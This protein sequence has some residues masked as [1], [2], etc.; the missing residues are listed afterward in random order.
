M[1]NVI[2]LL[3]AL[4]KLSPTKVNNFSGDNSLRTIAGN[5]IPGL[6]VDNKK[7]PL[8]ASYDK[9]DLLAVY[10]NANHVETSTEVFCRVFDTNH[11][12]TCAIIDPLVY[13]PWWNK[14]GQDYKLVYGSPLNEVIENLERYVAWRSLPSYKDFQYQK[15]GWFTIHRY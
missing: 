1:K 11:F 6:K 8:V 12:E 3:N 13:L 10:G 4:K 14:D 15:F 7:Y 5:C 9:V 2:V